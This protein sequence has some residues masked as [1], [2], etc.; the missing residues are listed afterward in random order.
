M[1]RLEIGVGDAKEMSRVI[2]LLKDV[3]GSLEHE[4]RHVVRPYMTRHF[5]QQFDTA[6]QHG[7]APWE[8]YGNEP[9]YAAM[10]QK[11]VGHL[12]LLRWEKGKRERL[13]PSVTQPSH[14]EHVFRADEDSMSM[15]TLVPY[16]ERL[17]EGGEGPFGETYPGR[18]WM[19]MKR[20]QK[21]DLITEIQRSIRR[22]LSDDALREARAIL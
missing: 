13:Y 12:E 3:I 16:A 8:G 6:G 14:P 21:S 10:K 15:G 18:N 19:R 2:G 4:W 22:R 11:I 17:I 20:A 9:Q 5:E 7:G 1:F